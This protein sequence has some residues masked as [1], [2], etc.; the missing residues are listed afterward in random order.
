[1]GRYL[2]LL[3][4]LGSLGALG[5]LAGCGPGPTSKLTD[6][7]IKACGKDDDHQYGCKPSEDHD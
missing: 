2:T 7:A 3:V 1:M 6:S 5:L 4:T